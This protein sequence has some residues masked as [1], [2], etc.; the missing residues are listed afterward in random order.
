MNSAEAC[1][2]ATFSLHLLH[3]RKYGDQEKEFE[4]EYEEVHEV[5]KEVGDT[6]TQ[7]ETMMQEGWHAWTML[8]QQNEVRMRSYVLDQFAQVVESNTE[9]KKKTLDKI[10][11]NF[12]PCVT[13][14]RQV[15]K[16]VQDLK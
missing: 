5:L 9:S 7:L 1:D 8:I 16:D 4:K 13:T 11:T 6:H 12:V 3:Y 15:Q 14:M 2:A 10:E